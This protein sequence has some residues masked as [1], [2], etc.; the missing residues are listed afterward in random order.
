MDPAKKRRVRPI[1]DLGTAEFGPVGT[2]HIG[3]RFEDTE[4]IRQRLFPFR[5]P[6]SVVGI[7]HAGVDFVGKGKTH[8][9]A[10]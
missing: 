6:P 8:S 2:E 5:E 9:N 1:A 10:P 3:I 4:E 7:R